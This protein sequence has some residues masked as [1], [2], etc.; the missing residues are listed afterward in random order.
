[1]TAFNCY[2][3]KKCGKAPNKPSI[4]NIDFLSFIF[5]V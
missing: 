4:S 5:K 3:R 1:M 2:Y